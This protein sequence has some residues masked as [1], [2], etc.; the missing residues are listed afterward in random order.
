MYT[1]P[2]LT[3]SGKNCRKKVIISSL[4]CI[5]STSAS[6]SD[7]NVV[8]MQAIQSVFYIQRM[9]Q[10]VELLIFVNHFL[11]QLITV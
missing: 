9:L 10:Q 8:V 1:C 4:M 6:G 7:Y 5:P 2:A 3:R 11:G